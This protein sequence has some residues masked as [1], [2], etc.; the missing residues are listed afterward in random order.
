M[1]DKNYFTALTGVRAVAA[2]MVFFHHQ[3]Q[4]N[5]FHLPLG[6]FAVLKEWHVGVTIF[7]VLSGF[8]ITY[9]YYDSV[10]LSTHWMKKYAVN[11]IARIY[12]MYILL[13]AGAFLFQYIYQNSRPDSFTVFSNIFLFKGFF[14]NLKFTGIAQSWSLTVEECFYFSAPLIFLFHRKTRKSF[15]LVFLLLG[16]G[17]LLVYLNSGES[18]YAFIGNDQFMLIYTFFGRCIEFF[19][20]IYL[21][22]FLKNH[23]GKINASTSVK[24]TI[25]GVIAFAILNIGMAWVANAQQVKFS[26]Y[27]MSGIVLNNVFLPLAIA[28][29]FYGLLAEKT[30]LKKIL[31][32]PLLEL[33]G[34]SSYV[35]YLIHLGFVV[36]IFDR[37]FPLQ[38]VYVHV[39]LLFIFI[40]LLSVLLYKFAEEPLRRFIKNIFLQPARQP[41]IR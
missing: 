8:L 26:I 25:A 21:A 6:I 37:I 12:P 30:I 38:N 15:L 1:Q 29:F 39:L 23:P 5:I 41:A 9:R 27:S 24:F 16:M 20:G 14:N 3:N 36:D 40:N 34:K 7:F 10:T 17:F 11:R 2:F 19:T 22:L 28:V 31:A 4:S 33:L 35:F 32:S 13:T 18:T